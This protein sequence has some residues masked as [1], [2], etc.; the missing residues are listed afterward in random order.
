MRKGRAMEKRKADLAEKARNA[1]S[2]GGG[3][4]S[5]GCPVT[6]TLAPPSCVDEN[7]GG[8]G[9]LMTEATVV[10]E[11]RP[12]DDRDERDEHI[13]LSIVVDERAKLRGEEERRSSTVHVCDKKEAKK[14]KQSRLVF[15]LRGKDKAEANG[16]SGNNNNGG[17]RG[18][19][20]NR[21]KKK[22]KGQTCS[23]GVTVNESRRKKEDNLAAI[24]M[25]FIVVFLVCHLPRLLLN[26]HEL[27]TIR[28]AMLCQE[29]GFYPFPLWSH[30]VICIS[31]LL[32][33][34]NSATNILIYCCL[35]SK[36]REECRKVFRKL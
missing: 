17:G 26:I 33:C 20:N 36:F 9:A 2:G 23:G 35:S 13:E 6:I 7:E 16:C 18:Y 24:F 4:V 34:L 32:L 5:N 14:K 1:E 12:E 29:N 19:R 8:D 28:H 30:L 25:G 10:T 21:D 3:G 27:V 22:K 31:H 11:A 15:K